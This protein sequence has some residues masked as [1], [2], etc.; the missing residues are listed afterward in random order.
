[1][2]FQASV[3]DQVKPAWLVL[4]HFK[5]GEESGS[6]RNRDIGDFKGRGDWTDRKCAPAE[7][8]ISR[9]GVQERFFQLLRRECQAQCPGCNLSCLLSNEHMECKQIHQ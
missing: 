7:T 3:N 8:G 5:D 9:L 2:C 1:M 4:H 6:Q